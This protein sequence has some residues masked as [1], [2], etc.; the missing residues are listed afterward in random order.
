MKLLKNTDINQHVIEQIEGKIPFYGPIYNLKLME[1]EILKTYLEIY[2]KIRFI[3]SFKSLTDASIF[4]HQKLDR[5]FC[6][7]INY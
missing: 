4:F 3:Q 5:N 6:F 1:L 7:Y 2:L